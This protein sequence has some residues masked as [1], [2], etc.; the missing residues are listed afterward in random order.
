[1]RFSPSLNRAVLAA[2]PGL[3]PEMAG[4]QA[5]EW[6]SSVG[7]ARQMLLNLATSGLPDVPDTIAPH[8]LSSG[9]PYPVRLDELL[10][11]GETDALALADTLGTALAALVATLI[12]APADA[13]MARPEWPASHWACWQAVERLGLG[14]G[15][16]SGVLGHHLLRVAGE[17]LMHWGVPVTLFIPPEPLY[18]PLRGV[19]RP[20]P[21]GPA[22]LLD[23]G[24]TSVKRA[25]AQVCG[26]EVVQLHPQPSLPAPLYL[27]GPGLAAFLAEAAAELATPDTRH[28]GLSLAV[29]TDGQ[30]QPL[31]TEGWRYASLG[32]LPL[33][34]TLEQHLGQGLQRP[35][36]VRVSHDGGAA[37]RA[38]DG[39]AD[40]AI[41]LGTSLGSGLNV[42]SHTI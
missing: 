5:F 42:I 37:A 4:T 36:Q 40:A 38:L 24:H 33:V 18:L 2:L 19:A 10:K 14:G 7:I 12:L 15:T 6:L 8:N 1:M 22:V 28:F 21:D 39:Q 13:R 20:L 25:L 3:P 41:M 35:V 32:S 11:A 16:V 26:G 31:E 23:A 17:F 27:S 34:P 29:Y 30:G 9:A